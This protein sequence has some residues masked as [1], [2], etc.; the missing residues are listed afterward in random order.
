MTCPYCGGVI[1]L[2]PNWKL[3]PEEALAIARGHEFR[4]GRHLAYGYG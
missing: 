1:P 2:S 4:H 3:A